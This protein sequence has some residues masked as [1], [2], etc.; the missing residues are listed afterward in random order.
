MQTETQRKNYPK[1]QFDIFYCFI[2]F[3]P[4]RIKIT[5]RFSAMD[6]NALS[7]YENFKRELK[8]LS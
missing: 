4:S 5:K 8:T 1:R 3:F 2:V 7:G 6:F